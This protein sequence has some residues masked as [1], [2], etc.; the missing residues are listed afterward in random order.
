M[1]APLQEGFRYER[2]LLGR[3]PIGEYQNGP[4]QNRDKTSPVERTW[5]GLERKADSPSC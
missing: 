3:R 2:V 4:W 1:L 5:V